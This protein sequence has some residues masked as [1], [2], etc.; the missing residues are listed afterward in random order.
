MTDHRLKGEAHKLRGNRLRGWPTQNCGLVPGDGRDWQSVNSWLM[1]RGSSLSKLAK[2]MNGQF[3]LDEFRQHL[4]EK[5]IT[6]YREYRRLLSRG[7]L[8]PRCPDTPHLVYGVL[9]SRILNPPVKPFSLRQF[10][11]YLSDNSVH[12]GSAYNRHRKAGK[13]DPRCP[14]APN[15]FY[16]VKI[17]AQ[18]KLFDSRELKEYLDKLGV[19]NGRTYDGLYSGGMLDERC[20]SKTRMYAMGWRWPSPRSHVADT[21]A[22]KLVEVATDPGLSR[23]EAAKALGV[24]NRVVEEI[25]N[26][27]HWSCDEVGYKPDGRKYAS[28]P[29]CLVKADFRRRTRSGRRATVFL[30]GENARFFNYLA[31]PRRVSSGKGKL[32]AED[33]TALGAARDFIS[34][35]RK[36]RSAPRREKAIV[37]LVRAL[38]AVASRS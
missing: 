7:L 11:Q 13:C 25:R 22:K 4:K 34:T 36:S 3:H 24:S 17:W 9:W 19:K 32:S 8:D 29:G 30:V 21:G 10:K 33:V 12:S 6:S 20:P 18:V 14:P 23:S 1:A 27:Q 31:L 26:G 16:E 38:R 15:I 2:E 28:R 5:S 37:K 35:W